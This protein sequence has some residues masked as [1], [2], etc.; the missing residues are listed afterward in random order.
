MKMH[1]DIKWSLSKKTLTALFIC[2]VMPFALARADQPKS[3]GTE[4]FHGYDIYATTI[5][6]EG[7]IWKQWFAGWMTSADLPWDRMYYS[8]S[9]DSG[10]TWSN[11]QLAFTIANV[12]VNDPTVLRLWD[13]VNS[14][15]YYLMYYTYYPSGFGDP[16]NY[17]AAS[18]SL[19]GINWTHHGVLIA[20]DNGIDT[21][22]AWSPTAYST[23]SI[24]SLVYVY[25]HNNHPDGRIY[26]TS[27]SGNLL[28]FDKTTTITVTPAGKLRANPDVSRSNDGKWWMFYNGASVTDDNKGNFNTCKMYSADG[29]NW[30]ESGLNPIQQYSKMTTCTPFVNWITDSTYQLWYGYGTPSFM[31]FSVYMQN[32]GSED[33][34]VLEIE[35]SS[36]A[37]EV[38]S[39]AKAFDNNPATFWS[40]NGH[41]GSPAFLE[42]IYLNLGI[43]KNIQEVTLTPRLVSGSAMCFPVDFKFQSS[44]DGIHWKD[45]SGQAYTNYACADSLS[46]KFIFDNSVATQY[47]RLYATKLSADSY[48][49][50]YCQLAE[51]SI[52][53]VIT[54]INNP[55]S[56]LYDESILLRNFPNPFSESTVIRYVL[57]MESHVIL[58]V[59]DIWG[60]EVATLVNEIQRA[61]TYA[62]KWNGDNNATERLALG[63]YICNLSINGQCF[64]NKMLI[65]R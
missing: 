7:S 54:S 5:V 59:Y 10:S 57:P 28:S 44:A 39:A 36:E 65:T 29:I 25:F 40:S 20:A 49:N 6:K 45:I 24:G 22:G 50:Y 4:I 31:D 34:P 3:P 16:T 23:D 43:V 8:F 38:M 26:R 12:Q 51:I 13:P 11:P 2:L 35:A 41:V 30:Q 18:T 61:G 17:I 9:T 46:Q 42:W 47:L 15:Y 33:E 63:V 52:T 1:L 14:G 62:I 60:R 27:F 19:D 21:D 55:I 48:G 32:F 58:K 37:L 56:G 53:S 64:S